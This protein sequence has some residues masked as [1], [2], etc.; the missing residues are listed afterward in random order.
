VTATFTR[1][2]REELARAGEHQSCCRQAEVS[3][4]IRTAGTFHIRGGGSEDE[5]YGLHLSTT[6]Q[7]AA[8]LVYSHFKGFGVEARL[9]TRREP[10]FGRRLRYEV[11]LGGS[12]AVLQALNELGILTDT[13]RLQDGIPS[14]LVRRRCCKS[15]FLR[16]CLIGAGSVSPPTRPAHIEILT[17]H[18]AFA[19][20]VA[21]LLAR[22]D[23]HPGV[24]ERRG[25]YVVYL[26]G[27]EEA[28]ELLAFAGAQQ[29]ALRVAEQAV[30]KEV[31]AQANRLANCD[32]ANSRRAS[33]AATRQLAAIAWLE[34]AGELE[35]L[36]PA[37]REMAEL[38]REHPYL[39]LGDLA[40]ASNEPLSRSAA[41]HRLRRLLALAEEAGFDGETGRARALC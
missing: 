7:A 30:V 24:Y 27:R 4:L 33:S 41:N 25:A 17:P 21:R 20:D 14:R 10:R 28:A 15:G 29:A 26:K 32:E 6:V 38:R 22:L 12:P 18:Q 5:R 40:A 2:V 11:H 37:L 23:F 19:Q 1:E 8:R 34:R 16:G 9:L 36:A 39:S 3:A 31:R 13:F 35:G